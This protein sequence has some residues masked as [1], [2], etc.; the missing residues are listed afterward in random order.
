MMDDGW[1]KKVQKV[2]RA[3]INEW[4]MIKESTESPGSTESIHWLRMVE[5]ISSTEWYGDDYNGMAFWQFWLS[6][7]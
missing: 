7:V 2:Q 3:Y 1:G 6:P 4:W 5:S